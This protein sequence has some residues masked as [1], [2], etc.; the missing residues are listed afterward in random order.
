MKKYVS[1]FFVRAY[2]TKFLRRASLK[3]VTDIEGGR[4][5]SRTL[6][7][8]LHRY[9]GVKV[10]DYSYGPCLIPGEWPRGISVGRY[11]SIADGV[12]V[13]RRNHPAE[14][15]AMHPFFYN[16]KLGFVS[17]DNIEE[18]ALGIGS[19]VWIGANVIITA[20]CKKI[21]D[22]AVIAA[23]S[24]VTKDIPPFAICGG[25]P[26]KVI[27]K[28]FSEKLSLRIMENPW[29]SRNI[30]ELTPYMDSFVRPLSEDIYV[31]IERNMV[32][33]NHDV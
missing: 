15:V 5:Y 25:I 20:G 6:R 30:D 14:R 17:Q 28:R 21:G 26:C 11:T 18:F 16:A 31:E 9:Y 19:D 4:F 32:G 29:W 8:I 1:E 33:L 3:L 10:G 22:G 7:A 2:R 24:V 27:K 12:K 13:F 23:G